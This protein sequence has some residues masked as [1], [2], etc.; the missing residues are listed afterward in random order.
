MRERMCVCRW[1]VSMRRE[2]FDMKLQQLDNIA[3][4]DLQKQPKDGDLLFV[5]AGVHET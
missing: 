5:G 4:D 2:K 1:R 3:N